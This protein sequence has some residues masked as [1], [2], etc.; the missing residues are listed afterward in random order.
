MACSAQL[1]KAAVTAAESKEP[2]KRVLVRVGQVLDAKTSIDLTNMPIELVK[3][4]GG[5]GM[6]LRATRDINADEV[7]CRYSARFFPT[8]TPRPESAEVSHQY[9]VSGGRYYRGTDPGDWGSFVNDAQ[10]PAIIQEL[11]KCKTIADCSRWESRM[12]TNVLEI[13]ALPIS[14]RKT[15]CYKAEIFGNKKG[16]WTVAL[17]AIRKGED[18]LT[19]YGPDYWIGLVSLRESAPPEA[20]MACV[21]WALWR[22]EYP[23]LGIEKKIECV[24]FP[25]T[26]P[27]GKI[28]IATMHLAGTDKAKVIAT[29][30]SPSLRNGIARQWLRAVGFSSAESG[31]ESDV[32]RENDL[33]MEK[34]VRAG[35]T[36]EPTYDTDFSLV[37]LTLNAA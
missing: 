11:E 19:M 7:I 24:S 4:Q 27:N 28:A 36:E 23:T 22:M 9:N 3:D 14:E 32:G 16:L 18:V 6:G 26:D 25:I 20:R 31:P 21:A 30:Q 8:E 29:L 2:T 35:T 34:C 17:R 5:R 33:W 1:E 15:N 13:G 37:G 12:L 10:D